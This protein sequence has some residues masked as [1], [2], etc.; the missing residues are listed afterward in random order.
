MDLQNFLYSQIPFILHHECGVDTYV[1]TYANSIRDSFGFNEGTIG[2]SRKRSQDLRVLKCNLNII[3]LTRVGDIFL[4][5]FP[6]SSREDTTR[7]KH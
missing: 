4:L 5:C 6:R 2:T 1:Q 3:R 7:L